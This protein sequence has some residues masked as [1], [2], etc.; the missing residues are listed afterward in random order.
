MKNRNKRDE[1]EGLSKKNNQGLCMTIL[2]YKNAHD[3]SVLFDDGTVVKS[4][5]K[6][7]KKGSTSN[8]KL[9]NSNSPMENRVGEE[10]TNNQGC[11][12]KIVRYKNTTDI[13]VQFDNDPTHTVN[14]T[15][16]QFKLKQI[17]NPFVPTLYGVGILG[18]EFSCKEKGNYTKE[19]LAWSA[20]IA[21]CYSEKKKK[22]KPTYSNCTVSEYFLYYP[23]F[24]RWI[25][26]QENYKV[27]KNTPL[28][29]VDKDIICK[30][31]KEYSPN[32]CCLVPNSINSLVRND[33][34]K[35]HKYVIGVGQDK[36]GRYVAHCMDYLTRQCKFLGSYDTEYEAFLA[37]KEAKEAVIKSA[38]EYEYVN[39]RITKQC[40]DALLK[41][42]VE[43]TD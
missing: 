25:I 39:G 8:P 22:E 17:H 6:Q 21:R 35:R 38:A 7:F 20:M 31:N 24:Y 2:E 5:W 41:Y 11:L 27:W 15:Y 30:G 4:D 40:R 19:Y 10:G 37:Y 9:P 13:T 14:G 28:F 12:M 18:N 23:N 36:N 43:I 29:A 33:S 26:S 42:E 32:K 16:R 34:S 1:R 3:I